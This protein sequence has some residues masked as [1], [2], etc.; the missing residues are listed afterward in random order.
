LKQDDAEARALLVGQ[1]AT[2]RQIPPA[3]RALPEEYRYGKGNPGK[4][5]AQIERSI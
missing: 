1:G 4:P 5:S 2:T 3:F